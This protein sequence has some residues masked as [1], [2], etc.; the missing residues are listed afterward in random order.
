MTIQEQID[1]QVAIIKEARDKL[2]QLFIIREENI[3]KENGQISLEDL[4]N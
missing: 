2:T 1:E 4:Q 3:N